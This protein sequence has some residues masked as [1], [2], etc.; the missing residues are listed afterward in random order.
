MRKFLQIVTLLISVLNI[1]AQINFSESFATTITPA[2]WTL[3]GGGL[4]TSQS[5]ATASWRGNLFSTTS[6]KILTTPTL[7]TSNGQPVTINFTYKV[8]NWSAATVATNPYNGTITTQVST[9]NGVSWTVQAGQINGSNHITA[10]T[11]AAVS[12]TVAGGQVP[13]ASQLRVRWNCVWGTTG[14]YYVYIDDVNI[15]QA[16]TVPPP[17]STTPNPASPTTNVALNPILSWATSTGASSY[18]V[19]FGNTSNPP[20]VATI[21]ANSYSPTG[22]IANTTYY[23]KVIPI[24]SIGAAT[25][26]AEWTFTTGSTLN[27]CTTIP[28]I[29]NAVDII[30]NV[31]MLTLNNSSTS[32]G[33]NNYVVYNNTP[34]NLIQGSTQSI[35]ITFGTDPNQ[36]SAVWID[37]NQNG[38][39]ET[40]ENVALSSVAAAGGAT[41]TYNINIPTTSVL[42]I[43]RMRVRGGSDNLYTAAGACTASSYGETEDYLVNIIA[44]S[45]CS[46]APT[47]VAITPTVTT[48]CGT[49]AAIFTATTTT[50]A[51]GGITYQW[52]SS[53]AGA[54]A[55]TNITGATGNS[56]AATGVTTSSNYVCILSCA[57]TSTTS[58][59]ATITVLPSVP[60]DE[61]IGAIPITV[62][63]NSTTCTSPTAVDTRCATQ[64]TNLSNIWTNSNDDDVWYSFTAS[65]TTQIINI[66]NVVFTGTPQNIGISVHSTTNCANVNATTELTAANVPNLITIT[67]GSGS[68]TISG[69]IVGNSYTL[70]LM[71]NGSLSRA[72]F[73]F[74]LQ[75]PPAVPTCATIVSPA[76]GST[77]VTYLPSIL[78]TWNNV[79]GATSYTLYFNSGAAGTVAT[80]DFGSIAASAGLTTT[81][82]ITVTNATTSY[83]WYVVPTNI[84]G[85]A[86][87]CNVSNWF[88]TGVTPP[89]PTNDNCTN[90]IDI[91]I[92]EGFCTSPTLGT[93]IGST[94]SNV[95]P[96]PTC[97]TFGL[98]NDVWY[99][100]T[101]PAGQNIIVQAT[102][103]EW[104]FGYGN[105][106]IIDAL[107]TS[108]GTCTGTLTS[109]A[110]DDDGNP[111]AAPN[112]AMPRIT[113]NNNTALPI[114]YLIRVRPYDTDDVTPFAI[115]AWSTNTTMVVAPGT[116]NACKP[117]STLVINTANG[118]RY[119]WLG[120]KD[121]S[122]EIVSEIFAN[123]NDLGTVT[124]NY[125]TTTNTTLRIAGSPYMNRNIAVNVQTQ[126][127]D[128]TY[129]AS[130]KLYFT[131]AEKI[132]LDLAAPGTNNL[133]D[134]IVTKEAGN[135]M[136]VFQNNVPVYL[137][138]SATNPNGNYGT[139]GHYISVPVT[140]FSDF[141]MHKGNVVLPVHFSNLRGVVSGAT[142]TLYWSTSWE[143]NHSKFVIER[144]IDGVN[145]TTLGT[146]LTNA[147]NG[148]T[149][150]TNQYSYIDANPLPGKAFYRLML[151]DRQNRKSNSPTVTLVRGNTK[152]E[153]VDVR[154]NPTTSTVYIN[155]LGSSSNTKLSL[156]D[157]YGK[158][159]Q[160][161]KVTNNNVAINLTNYANGIYIIQAID[162]TTGFKS[163]VRV[164]KQ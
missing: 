44:A 10:N 148:T 18:Q 37:F 49:A 60:N 98:T 20:L 101:V 146:V 2:G 50:T 5:C 140:S 105:D 71:T 28:G 36:H 103:V 48:A 149:T 11:C 135:C 59:I 154:P 119:T 86:I 6:G 12:Y 33:T 27:Y 109:A 26:C 139:V 81:V 64:S 16:G 112:N 122:N 58:N 61:C 117:A 159:L 132:A 43:T 38:T 100:V 136:S 94:A 137:L 54:N 63:A 4:S 45:P 70:R 25:G 19:Y 125:Y 120:I 129:P 88:T 80:T 68:S 13:S 150:E 35:S 104:G 162:V 7:G 3:S 72:S 55:F 141:F 144:S 106:L 29:V 8:V 115:C 93:L 126:P 156:Y 47:G 22:L 111:D 53:V 124:T 157:V 76:N 110:C 153:I 87:G 158:Q 92:S 46:G 1:S 40:S 108:N 89:A 66:S 14:D 79:P 142:N 51:S 77:G 78:L 69:L 95:T 118:N 133:A 67:N 84:S 151:L 9:D 147:P 163:V 17:C 23:W 155:V 113:L 90:A 83:V 30:T 96:T 145:Y 99:K 15:I 52:Q 32:N 123:G 107:Q 42:G 24:N 57:G 73:N 160:Q 82:G 75:A 62:Q 138:Q 128:P 134:I 121:A 114:T 116:N 127:Q 102:A 74:C 143:E 152:L 131:I 97:G 41:V 164:V 65:A 34:V 91:P 161:Y 56:Y 31:S 85:A 21:N 130:V 39:Y